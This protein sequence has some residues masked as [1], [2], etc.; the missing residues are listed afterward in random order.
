MDNNN[1]FEVEF[2]LFEFWT[3]ETALY[4]LFD[5]NLYITKNMM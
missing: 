4:V 5:Y 2:D 3:I 1:L